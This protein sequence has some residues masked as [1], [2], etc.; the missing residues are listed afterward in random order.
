M[1]MNITRMSE[2]TLIVFDL[3]AGDDVLVTNLSLDLGGF[4]P[5]LDGPSGKF[6]HQGQ[7]L[8]W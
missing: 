3:G 5:R 2:G 7:T 4:I 6:F 8:P 1:G